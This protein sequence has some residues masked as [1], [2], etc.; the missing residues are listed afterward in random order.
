MPPAMHHPCTAASVGFEIEWSLAKVLPNVP[1][2][3]TSAT[4]SHTR[5]RAASSPAC[6]TVDQS[7]PNPAQKALPSARTSTTRTSL[8]ASA[9]SSAA[10]SS[11]RSSTVIVLNSSGRHSTRW[12]TAPSSSM[13][14][15]V[16]M[17]LL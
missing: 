1:I 6:D 11:S 4:V 14:I 12:R 8:S 10:P 15:A 5:P 3:R 9:A 16:P 17:T 13:R 2:I 7:S